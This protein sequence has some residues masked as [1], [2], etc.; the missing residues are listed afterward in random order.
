MSAYRLAS[1]PLVPRR[2]SL[3][4]SSF[5]WIRRCLVLSGCI[6]LIS[7]AT[8]SPSATLIASIRSFSVSFRGA[9]REI[10]IVTGGFRLFWRLLDSALG[11]RLFLGGF[12]DAFFAISA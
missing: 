5:G 9:L 11:R 2:I 4:F 6:A 10:L 12:L 3:A 7:V 8:Y 1:Q